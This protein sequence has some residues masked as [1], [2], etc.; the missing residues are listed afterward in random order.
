MELFLYQ[1]IKYQHAVGL[2]VLLHQTIKHQRATVLRR[3]A[4]SPPRHHEQRPRLSN[5]PLGLH[6]HYLSAS[7]VGSKP[8]SDPNASGLRLVARHAQTMSAPPTEERGGREGVEVKVS[9]LGLG[10]LVERTTHPGGPTHRSRSSRNR[11]AG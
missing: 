9:W 4:T 5:P 7:T 11:R 2:L 10:W 3:H 8:G 1:T 6:R